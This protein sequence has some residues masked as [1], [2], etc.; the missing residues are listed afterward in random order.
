MVVNC[1]CC[2]EGVCEIKVCISSSFEDNI[3]KIG[4]ESKPGSVLLATVM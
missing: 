2:G 3:C 4:Y 1:L